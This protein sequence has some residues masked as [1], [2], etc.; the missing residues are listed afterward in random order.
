LDLTSRIIDLNDLSISNT[1]AAIRLGKKE[2]AKIVKKQA[3]QEIKSQATADWHIKISFLILVIIASALMMI[4][5]Q[6]TKTG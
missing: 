5:L 4:I 1:I 2:G 3:K 6:K